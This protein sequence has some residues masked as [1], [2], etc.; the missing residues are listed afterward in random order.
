MAGMSYLTRLRDAAERGTLHGAYLTI[1]LA[2]PV[3]V[4]WF[5]VG[6]YLT[7]RTQA[8]QGAA[9]FNYINQT[10]QAQQKA[11]QKPAGQ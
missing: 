2:I 10:I 4:L 7:L 11:A 6:D 5:L 3:L 9:A 1:A 8:Q